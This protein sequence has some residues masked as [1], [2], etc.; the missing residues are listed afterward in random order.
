MPLALQLSTEG[1]KIL[2]NAVVDNRQATGRIGMGMGIDFG[3]LPMGGPAGMPDAR[4][5]R[6][7]LLLQQ[8]CQGLQA[9]HTLAKLQFPSPGDRQ[10]GGIIPP[11]FQPLQSIHQDGNR[12]PRANISHNAAHIILRVLPIRTTERNHT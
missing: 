9:A 4:P 2:D 7:R 11:V 8:V 3:R 1:F 5:P 12:I 6:Q 10:P